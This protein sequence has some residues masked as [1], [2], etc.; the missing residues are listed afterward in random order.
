MLFGGSTKEKNIEMSNYINPM[1][2]NSVNKALKQ[3]ER[4]KKMQKVRRKLSIGAKNARNVAEAAKINMSKRKSFRKI[5]NHDGGGGDYFQ[6]VETG[7]TM[8][9]MPED[10]ELLSI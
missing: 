9:F 4:K 8:W 10:G 6:N 5:E 7:E 1:E 2:K 3:Q